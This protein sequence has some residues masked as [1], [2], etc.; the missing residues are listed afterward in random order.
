MTHIKVAS[1]AGSGTWLATRKIKRLIR[2]FDRKQAEL[3]KST[4]HEANDPRVTNTHHAP[5]QAQATKADAAPRRRK[6]A[7]DATF[8]VRLIR[9]IQVIVPG[10][11]SRE[12]FQLAMLTVALVARTFLTL[13]IAEISTY[14]AA[15][16]PSLR[17]HTD[18]SQRAAM[19]ACS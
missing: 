19:R 1:I 14:R 18:L 3:Y 9:L 13:K 8:L 10:P 16:A 6:V 15:V 5:Q 7:V 17:S 4:H 11:F 12:A 2:E